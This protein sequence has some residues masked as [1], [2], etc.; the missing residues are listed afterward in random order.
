MRMGE[1]ND[2]DCRKILKVEEDIESQDF[3]DE[4]IK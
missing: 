2:Q 4:K 1:N 3:S